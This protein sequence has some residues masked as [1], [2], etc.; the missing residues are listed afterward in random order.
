LKFNSHHPRQ[1]ACRIPR[2]SFGRR[3][4]KGDILKRYLARVGFG[5]G[6]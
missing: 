6:L 5:E 3:E 1:A 2:N 4:Q